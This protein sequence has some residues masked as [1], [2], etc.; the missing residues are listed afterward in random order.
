MN[1]QKNFA[2]LLLLV[3][4]FATIA[5]TPVEAFEVGERVL[6]SPTCSNK[7]WN[8]GTILKKDQY[9]YSVKLD[10]REGQLGE[11]I[12]SLPLN[13]VRADNSAT[14]PASTTTSSK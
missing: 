13:W 2:R 11:E 9:S 8:A 5:V 7:D 12:Y 10:K 14:V 6:C 1:S 3:I 4:S